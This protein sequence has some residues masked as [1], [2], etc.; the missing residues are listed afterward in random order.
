MHLLSQTPDGLSGVQMLSTNT[1]IN[2]SQEESLLLVEYVDT[3]KTSP[4]LLALPVSQQVL[5][6]LDAKLAGVDIVVH[7]NALLDIVDKIEKFTNEVIKNAKN[8]YV[9]EKPVEAI[10][11]VAKPAPPKPKLSRANSRKM[12]FGTSVKIA[13]WGARAKKSVARK[14][15]IIEE[16]PKDLEVRTY[17]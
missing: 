7:Q 13:Q 3:K 16:H 15:S 12:S 4:D 10:V 2:D 6:K 1:K 17:M 14:K 11:E 5:K 9:P 8:L